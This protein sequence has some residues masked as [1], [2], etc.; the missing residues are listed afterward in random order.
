MPYP[1]LEQY[2]EQFPELG[3]YLPQLDEY[4]SKVGARAPEDRVIVPVQLA[5]NLHIN[6]IVAL[7]LLRLSDKAGIL[8]PKYFVRCDQ[9]EFFLGEFESRSDIPSM[10]FCAYHGRDHAANE[11]Y[12]ELV[13]VFRRNLMEIKRSDQALQSDL[14]SGVSRTA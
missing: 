8:A 7:A 12:V 1:E 2:R 10:L 13:F 4:L 14:R 6:E 3:Q 9:S 5:H 11:Y